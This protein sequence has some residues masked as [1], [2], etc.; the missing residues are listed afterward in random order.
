[1]EQFHVEINAWSSIMQCMPKNVMENV[2]T[3]WN[4][5]MESV[6]LGCYSVHTAMKRNMIGTRNIVTP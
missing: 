4:H 3:T 2:L 6:D 1:M 5:V